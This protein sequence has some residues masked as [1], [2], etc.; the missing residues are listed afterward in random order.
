MKWVGTLEVPGN[1]RTEELFMCEALIRRDDGLVFRNTLNCQKYNPDE[2]F[3]RTTDRRGFLVGDFFRG[4]GT[5][6]GEKY[7]G[8]GRIDE[9]RHRR[10]K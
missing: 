10:Q 6:V 4:E 8:T 3:A 5:F 1:A 2:K 9:M 7:D